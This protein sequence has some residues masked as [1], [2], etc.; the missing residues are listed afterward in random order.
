MLPESC[1]VLAAPVRRLAGT[2][3]A[4]PGLSLKMQHP[5]WPGRN[6]QE[7]LGEEEDCLSP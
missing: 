2:L 6:E 4:E 5:S 1:W 7:V 3:G